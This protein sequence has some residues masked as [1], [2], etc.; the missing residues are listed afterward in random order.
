MSGVID[1]GLAVTVVCPQFTTA[2]GLGTADRRPALRGGRLAAS[3]L[4]T[5]SAVDGA[6]QDGA[7][8]HGPRRRRASLT[9]PD[10]PKTCWQRRGFVE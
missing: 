1:S 5:L 2:I 7:L 8:C 6:G 4:A 10:K 3:A 9:R